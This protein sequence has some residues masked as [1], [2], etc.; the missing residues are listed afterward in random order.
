MLNEAVKVL[1]QNPDLK[2]EIDGHT[3]ST[4]PAEYNMVLSQK[5]AQAVMKYFVDNGV[6]AGRLTAKGFGLTQ[7]VADNGTK[8]GRAKN[9]RVELKPV[10]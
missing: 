4:G 10:K 1:G 7:P 3:D 9:R 2:V 8:E 5:R 6:D